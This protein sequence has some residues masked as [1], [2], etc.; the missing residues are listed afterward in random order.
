MHHTNNSRGR[1]AA[2]R[3]ALSAALGGC[4]PAPAPL[5]TGSHV[6][7][8]ILVEDT[9]LCAGTVEHLDR[10]VERA[11]AFLDASIPPDFVVPITIGYVEDDCEHGAG[12][13][14]H[15]EISVNTVD[16]S[17]RAERPGDILRHELAHAVHDRAWGSSIPFFNEGLATSLSTL[18]ESRPALLPIGDMLDKAALELSYDAAGRFVRFLI[19]TR[20][21]ARFRT[22][23]RGA[24]GRD[25]AGTRA[26]FG[27]VYGESFEDI[28]AEYLSGDPRCF[29]QLHLCDVAAAERIDDDWSLTIPASCHDTEFFGAATAD[30]ELFATTRTL[31][32][33]RGGRYFL[34]AD[35]AYDP[36]DPASSAASVDLVRCGT[37]DEIRTRG[38]PPGGIEYELPAG[39][40][41]LVITMPFDTV[42][43]VRISSLDA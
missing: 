15:G 34:S 26:W 8:D 13:Y 19:D 9:S 21:L 37:C 41:T 33:V 38:V 40:Y 27:E 29:Y 7:I 18:T 5:A 43:S 4:T 16:T 14:S 39:I 6:E 23:Y 36:T 32:L 31:E 3:L 25:A 24:P 2:V 12:C 35:F 17:G 30:G 1:S 42:V 10:F 28:E 20:G 22:L 11:F